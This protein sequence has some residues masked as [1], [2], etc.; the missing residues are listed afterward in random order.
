MEQLKFGVMQLSLEL[1]KVEV[2]RGNT[3]AAFGEIY[4]SLMSEILGT[5][6]PENQNPVSPDLTA[7]GTTEDKRPTAQEYFGTPNKTE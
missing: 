1:L 2:S 4:S 5:N 3:T 7:N 6:K